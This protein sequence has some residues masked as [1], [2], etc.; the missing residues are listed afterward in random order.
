[1]TESYFEMNNIDLLVN[2]KWN[3]PFLISTLTFKL[4]TTTWKLNK[5]GGKTVEKSEKSEIQW[6][7]LIF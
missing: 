3:E 4:T 6:I 5:C 7:F 2:F 1:M